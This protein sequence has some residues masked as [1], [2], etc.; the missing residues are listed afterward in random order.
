[1]P[2]NLCLSKLTVS[3]V[4]YRISLNK[5]ACLNK[6]APRLLTLPA[7]ISETTEPISLK[8]SDEDKGSLSASAPGVFIQRNTV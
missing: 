8:L 5:R 6:R 3:T 1:M 4:D 2:R 7:D